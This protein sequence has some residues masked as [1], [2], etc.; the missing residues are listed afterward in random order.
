MMPQQIHQLLELS[1][2]EIREQLAALKDLE[3][4]LRSL[5]RAAERREEKQCTSEA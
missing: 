1:A 2:A 4:A 3:K 5:L